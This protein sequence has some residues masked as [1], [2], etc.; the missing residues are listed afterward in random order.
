MDFELAVSSSFRELSSEE[1]KKEQRQTLE[2]IGLDLREVLLPL[3]LI[4]KLLMEQVTALE[5]GWLQ[6][7]ETLQRFE[8]LIKTPFP[9]PLTCDIP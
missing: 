5:P 7:K 2:A 8:T 9:S 4:Q 6:N 1:M 3:I